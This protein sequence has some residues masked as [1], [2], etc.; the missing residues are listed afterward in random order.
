MLMTNV[1]PVGSG[2][3][4]VDTVV[5]ADGMVDGTEI[6]VV[7]DTENDEDDTEDD[8]GTSAVL[9]ETDCEEFNVIGTVPG[10]LVGQFVTPGRQ[11]VTVT[12]LVTV[13]V[14]YGAPE[15]V[16]GARSMVGPCVPKPV[17]SS[18]SCGVA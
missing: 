8:K 17:K 3:D 2:I 10:I 13:V 7:T 12:R 6:V 16:V 1:C 15:V 11:D 9:S 4:E 5:V 14:E 18:T